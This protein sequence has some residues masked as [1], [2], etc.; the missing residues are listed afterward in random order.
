MKNCLLK[1]LSTADRL[2]H[3]QINRLE[4]RGSYFSYFLAS[5]R[6]HPLP[7]RPPLALVWSSSFLFRFLLE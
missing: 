4:Q 7:L 1:V 6:L 2:I 5:F 3:F